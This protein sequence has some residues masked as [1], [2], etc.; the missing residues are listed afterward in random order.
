MI[1][2]LE[3]F[4]ALVE[5]ITQTFDFEAYL[6][7]FNWSVSPDQTTMWHT[8]SAGG[9]GFNTVSYSNPEVDRLLDEALIETDREK[10]IEL[11][12][13]MQNIIMEDLPHTILDF[14]QG[15]TGVSS[16]LHNVYASGVNARFNAHLW[17]VEQ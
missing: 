3:P 9:A 15:F 5:R 8:D 7:G 4:P 13:E 1:P 12:T 14:P 2:Q 6:I 10:R 11:Y 16:R 17:W